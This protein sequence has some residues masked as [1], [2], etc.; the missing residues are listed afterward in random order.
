MSDDGVLFAE[1]S[2]PDEEPRYGAARIGSVRPFYPAYHVADEDPL[3]AAAREVR[4]YLPDLLGAEANAVDGTLARVLLSTAPGPAKLSEIQTVFS[5]YERLVDWVGQFM[6]GGL[7][8][9]EFMASVSRGH[10]VGSGF[11]PGVDLPGKDAQR[12]GVRF[13]CPNG[14]F[15]WYVLRLGEPVPDCPTCDLALVRSV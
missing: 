6:T 8:P 15:T 12:P 11:T 10:A 9:P 1:P 2:G 5:S 13:T 14:D 7:I 3:F 4:P